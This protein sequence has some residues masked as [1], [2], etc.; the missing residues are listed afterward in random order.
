M[1]IGPPD[2]VR[3]ALDA[4]GFTGGSIDDATVVYL[5]NQLNAAGSGIAGLWKNYLTGKGFEGTLQDAQFAW[6]GSLGYTGGMNSRIAQ[7]VLDGN[8][9]EATPTELEASIAFNQISYGGDESTTI[10]FTLLRSV[11]TDQV[12]TV[13]WVIAGVPNATPASGTVTFSL[14][15]TTKV[16]SITAG[17]VADGGETGTLTLSNPTYVSGPQSPPSITAPLS[18]PFQIFGL[19]QTGGTP[20]GLIAPTNITDPKNNFHAGYYGMTGTFGAAIPSEIIT[21]SNWKGFMINVRWR[22]VETSEGV[23][24]WSATPANGGNSVQDYYDQLSAAG[25]YLVVRLTHKTFGSTSDSNVVSPAYIAADSQYGGSSP[26]HGN[27]GFA[28]NVGG[29]QLILTDAQLLTKFET[30]L[31][32]FATWASGKPFFE[33]ALFGESSGLNDANMPGNDAAKETAWKSM[34]THLATAIAPKMV[35]TA[36]NFAQPWMTVSAVAKVI[37]PEWDN[38]NHSDKGRAHAYSLCEWASDNGIGINTPDLVTGDEAT[39]LFL[40]ASVYRAMIDFHDITPCG[41]D[42]EFFDYWG[43]DPIS[44]TSNNKNNDGELSVPQ[45]RDYGI[46]KCNPHYFFWMKRGA[47]WSGVPIVPFPSTNV[48][49]MI[50]TPLPAAKAFEDSLNQEFVPPG[51]T[52]EYDFETDKSLAAKNGRGP[53]LGITRATEATYF[54]AVGLLQTAASGDPRFQHDPAD[55]TSLGLLIEEARTNI[56]IRSE[57]F[58]HA[59]WVKSAQAAVTANAVASPDGTANADKL[60][61]VAP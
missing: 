52:L 28:T 22:D 41:P 7:F 47:W 45:I 13:D 26:N 31:T 8:M 48:Q 25:K 53:T 59:A 10:I 44:P 51:I 18:V 24:N 56:A 57:D 21:D 29:W 46:E 20:T 19:P 6:L 40:Q 11:R 42:I 55:N 1:L 37:F 14:G 33:F 23:F 39:G 61:G 36:A 54:D 35:H 34:H 2:K 16:V 4:L 30:F 9:L 49:Q 5:V 32:E 38:S 17:A 3:E 50:A 58:S 43:P 12:I 15:E 60:E 27:I